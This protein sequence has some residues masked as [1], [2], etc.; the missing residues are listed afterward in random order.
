M[1]TTPG[2]QDDESEGG[3]G[4]EP[5]LDP[6]PHREGR[7]S[8][9]ELAF[10]HRNVLAALPIAA[11]FFVVQRTDV[12]WIHWTVA[13]ILCCAGAA[14]RAWARW[15]NTYARGRKKQLATTGP[16]AF[17]RNPLY[18]GNL[19]ILAGVGVAAQLAWLLPLAIGW[20]FLVYVSAC[21]H[22][23]R[24]MLLKYGASYEAYRRNVPGWFPRAW[25][26]PAAQIKGGGFGM[27]LAAQIFYGCLGLLPFVLKEIDPFRFWP[28]V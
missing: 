12:V 20:A 10:R 17:V 16:Y 26:P 7:A 6:E 1:N 5:D 14:L 9:W 15:H 3:S 11:A 2:T 24:R 19:L 22:E 8:L 28:P 18:I 4:N 13:I 25:S 21:R 23:E 27:V